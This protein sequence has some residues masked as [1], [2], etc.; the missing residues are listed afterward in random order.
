MVFYKYKT[1]KINL[2]WLTDYYYEISLFYTFM[3]YN[4][5]VLAIKLLILC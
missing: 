4:S 5:I 2:I 1:S 3:E